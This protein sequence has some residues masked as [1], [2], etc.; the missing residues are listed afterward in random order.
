MHGRDSAPIDEHA[1]QIAGTR[2]FWRSA[3]APS[4][5]TRS[6]HGDSPGVAPILY[7][8]GVPTNADDWTPFLER[9]GGVALDLPGFGRSEKANT[10]DYSIGGYNAFLQALLGRLGW[11]R[12]SL[13]VHDWGALALVTA[14]ELRE[15]IDRLVIMNAVPLLPGYRW[16]RIARAW[17]TPLIGEIVMGLTTRTLARR[18]SKESRPT[19]EPWP[20]AMVDA[21]WRHFDHGTQRAILRLYRS[22]PPDAL[23]RAGALLGD[24]EADTLVLW[25]ERDPYIPA[26]FAREYASVLPHAELKLLSDAGHWPWLDR[27]DVP[28]IV[29]TFLQGASPAASREPARHTGE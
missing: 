19:G 16:H 29:A 14:Q 21:V 26:R 5:T 2:T 6:A 7:A 8:H 9:S 13:V 22:A 12:F 10:F 15:R 23:E 18:L 25:G 1:E 4:G 11:E 27:P 28:E 17:R 24:M 20:E 3:P